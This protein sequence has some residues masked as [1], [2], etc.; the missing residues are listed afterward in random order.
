MNR[1]G[2]RSMN[3]ARTAK[4]ER[5]TMAAMLILKYSPKQ[6]QPAGKK[7]SGVY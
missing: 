4:T 5:V 7:V 3:A 2:L 6:G 1:P